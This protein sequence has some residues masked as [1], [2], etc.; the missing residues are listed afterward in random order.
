MIL[1]FS[2]KALAGKDVAADY[3][4]ANYNWDVK[5]GF[6]YNLKVACS[7]IL[8]MDLEA[9]TTQVGKC[10]MLAE[11]VKTDYCLVEKIVQ[12]MSKTHDVTMDSIDHNRLIGRVLKTPRD[13]LQFV[14]TDIMRSYSHNYHRDVLI[15]SLSEDNNVIVTDVR[16]PNE[17]DIIRS[18]GGYVIRVERPIA[19]RRLYGE[20]SNTK[21]KS[22]VAL[23]TWDDWDYTLNNDG[24][25]LDSLYRKIDNMVDIL[26]I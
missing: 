22:E 15:L 26:G 9:F 4:I 17:A 25:E 21:H 18:S 23:D 11:P 20:V 14:G 16:F 5:T 13:I 12:W 7:E 24:K 6:A 8:N 3:L 2:G 10:A 19:L 1:G